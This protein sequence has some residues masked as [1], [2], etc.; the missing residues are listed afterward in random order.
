M[1]S[2]KTKSLE[3]FYFQGGKSYQ[4][5][6]EVPLN[7]LIVPSP[8]PSP[9]NTPTPSITPTISVSPSQTPTNSITPTLTPSITLSPTPTKTNTPTP[10]LTRTPTPTPYVYLY[11]CVDC[12]TG[13]LNAIFASNTFYVAGKI[14]QG[15]ILGDCYEV[16]GTTTGAYNDVVIA[17]FNDCIDCPL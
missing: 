13:T 5:G 14:V 12:S 16:L 8:S 11:D 15:S 4:Y 1:S 10:T 9:T 2:I 7:A 3:E 6:G 17:S